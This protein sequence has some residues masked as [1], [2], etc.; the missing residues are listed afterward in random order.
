MSTRYKITITSIECEGELDVKELVRE[1]HASYKT[2][3]IS[4][5]ERNLLASANADRGS[6]SRQ[7]EF[8]HRHWGRMLQVFL[9]VSGKVFRWIVL[10]LLLIFG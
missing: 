4:S 9:E 5:I 6:E 1:A 10:P 8:R 2:E 3:P 7:P